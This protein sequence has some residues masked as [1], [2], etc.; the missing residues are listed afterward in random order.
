M[1]TVTKITNITIVENTVIVSLERYNQLLEKEKL[2]EELTNDLLE[3]N[4]EQNKLRREINSLRREITFL[5]EDDLKVSET[6]NFSK[7][8]KN[9]TQWDA[10][11][12]SSN[13]SKGC[14]TFEHT[15]NL[16]W[17]TSNISELRSLEKMND[18]QRKY[19]FT[20]NLVTQ[21][22]LIGLAAMIDREIKEFFDKL[23]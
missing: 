16:Q 1:D 9:V 23:K 8:F 3:S 19:C 20:N 15:L 5:T 17:D 4:E 14:T 22:P 21:Y 10:S 6:T 7:M 13:H 2:V 11:K 12:V 18:E